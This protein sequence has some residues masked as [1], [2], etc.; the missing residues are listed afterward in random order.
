[1]HQL[2]ILF[3]LL[4]QTGLSSQLAF[5]IPKMKGPITSLILGSSSSQRQYLLSQAGYNFTIIKP[6]IDE[7]GIGDRSGGSDKEDSFSKGRKLV[8]LVGIAKVRR[9]RRSSNDPS[10][11]SFCEDI[12]TYN[13][14]SLFL[15]L[16]FFSL[17]SDAILAKIKSQ[18]KLHN[19][20]PPRLLLTCDQIVMIG[21]KIHEK[22]KTKE[23]AKSFIT[24]YSNNSCSTIGS[25]VVTDLPTNNRVIGINTCK[26]NFKTIPTEIIDVV[27]DEGEILNCA[28]GLMI[29][30][31]KLIPYLIGIDHQAGSESGGEDGVRGLSLSLLQ[32]CIEE[33]QHHDGGAN[34]FVE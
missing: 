10:K 28:G 19:I 7:Y 23:E 33:L 30:N 11:L 22:P 1:M 18:P 20:Q 14:N 32:R 25:L 31:P 6:E 2:C 17:K 24:L 15:S 3:L 13:T 34:V 12:S 21:N 27:V 5:P 8:C 26:I 16:L 4:S 29:E 9:I